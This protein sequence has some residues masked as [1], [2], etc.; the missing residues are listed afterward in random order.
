MST[1][2]NEAVSALKYG[3][4][5]SIICKEVYEMLLVRGCPCLES[6]NSISGLKVTDSLSCTDDVGRELG[7]V[8]LQPTDGT[9]TH[10]TCVYVQCDGGPVITVQLY[11]PHSCLGDMH[12]TS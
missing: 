4:H 7:M 12:Q 1:R 2:L 10:G 11:T 3:G 9:S 8:Q 6:S 5:H